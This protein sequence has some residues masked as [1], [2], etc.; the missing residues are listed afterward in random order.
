MALARHTAGSGT[1]RCSSCI[2][3]PVEK[4]RTFWTTLAAT[5]HRCM[6]KVS[7]VYAYYTL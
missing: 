2:L 5:V 4:M 1:V 6:E 3:I 7:I